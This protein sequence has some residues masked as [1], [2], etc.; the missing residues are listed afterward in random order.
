MVH[1][2]QQ[3]LLFLCLLLMGG[4]ASSCTDYDFVETGK[5]KAYH[6]TTMLSYLK[7]D[8]YNYRFLVYLINRA[9]LNDVFEGKSQYGSEITFIAPTDLSIRR[10][11]LR[12][13]TANNNSFDD[14]GSSDGLSRTTRATFDKN[15]ATDSMIMHLIDSISVDS[16]RNIVLSHIIPHANLQ[17]ED[18]VRGEKSTS[19]EAIGKGGKIYTMAS[20]LQLWIYSF[21]T[22]YGGVAG[23]GP[24][25]LHVVSPTT[26]VERTVASHNIRTQTGTVHA[27]QYNFTLFEF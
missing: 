12:T 9:G 11:L 2:I 3:G 25:G 20:G 21:A 16:C 7:G 5:A 1:R 18:F 13:Y 10:Y 6:D 26:Q 17:L 24:L 27:L 23:A 22:S 8:T 14:F 19:G 4:L 15:T